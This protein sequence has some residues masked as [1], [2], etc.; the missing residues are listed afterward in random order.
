M[1]AH[2]YFMFKNLLRIAFEFVIETMKNIKNS[3]A[4]KPWAYFV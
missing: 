2:I 3:E 4:F 1:V